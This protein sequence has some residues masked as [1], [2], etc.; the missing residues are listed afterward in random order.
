MNSDKKVAITVT[1]ASQDFPHVI[2]LAEEYGQVYLLKNNEPRYLLLDLE[3][4][5]V[6]DMT[7]DGKIDFVAARILK[8]HINAFRELEKW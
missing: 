4:S 1:E 8:R 3:K 2:S 7:E 6:I 5:P